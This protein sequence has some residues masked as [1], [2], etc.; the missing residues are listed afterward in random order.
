LS[1]P[2]GRTKKKEREVGGSKRGILVLSAL[3]FFLRL[4]HLRP[5]SREKEPRREEAKETLK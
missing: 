4:C 5:F 3:F 2:R 1:F